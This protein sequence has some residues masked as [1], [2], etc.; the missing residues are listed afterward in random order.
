MSNAE[1]KKE[2]A[3]GKIM[4]GAFVIAAATAIGAAAYYKPENDRLQK[5]LDAANKQLKDSQSIVDPRLTQAQAALVSCKADLSAL[6]KNKNDALITEVDNLKKEQDADTSEMQMI[7]VAESPLMEGSQS[8]PDWGVKYNLYKQ[9]VDGDTAAITSL[10]S[11][12]Q[13]AQRS[14]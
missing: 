8:P 11:Q 4:T 1:G 5:E 14:N 3:L 6:V 9:R 10:Y 2:G 7:V 13:C 12:Y